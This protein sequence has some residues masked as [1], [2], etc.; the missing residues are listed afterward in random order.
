[1]KKNILTWHILTLI[2]IFG[3]LAVL[4]G[5]VFIASS[6][7]APLY[8]YGILVTFIGLIT[9]GVTFTKY[10]DPYILAQD[11]PSE[12][13]KKYS[14]SCLVAV[15]NEEKIIEQCILSMINQTYK[16]KEIIIINDA[17]TDNTKE[18]LDKY[19]KKGLIN[20]IHLKENVGKKKAL[21]Q[22]MLKAKGEIFAFSDSDSVWA[23]DA[24]EK[25]VDVFGV[26][27][28]IGAVSG[29][30]R[31]LNAEK[32]IW[33]KVQDSWYE[34]QYSIR[35]AFESVYGAVTCVSGPLAVFRREAIFNFI[36][37]WEHDKFLG[38]EFRFATD[39]TL[40][41]FVL[42][43]K[44]IGNKL[45]KKYAGSPFLSVDYPLKDWKIVYCKSAKAWTVVPET[46]KKMCLQQI[47]WKKSFIRNIFFTGKFYW[48]KPIL[49]AAGYY[50]HILFVLAGPFIAF[51]HL[52]YLPLQGNVYSAILY[53]AG[54]TFVGL[55][56]G[57]AY[58]LENKNCNRWI[59]RP[60]MSLLSSL[61]YCWLIFYSIVTIKKNIWV[62]G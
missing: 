57:I 12:K 61:I 52:V 17:S 28:L 54:I 45:K 53:L 62:R 55:M 51:R 26:D 37:A 32:N 31:V 14:V 11:I 36:P 22:G 59:Y 19:A 38:Q 8:L 43:S 56:F 3:I 50:L 21:A 35:K 9:F 30:C 25:I 1:M 27:P 7:N 42:G 18:V 41:G 15:R 34:G 33:T 29:H 39:R 16:N 60:I 44:A 47:R 4:I 2:I 58:K 40:T 6:P 48:R 20:V 49:P 5:K 23:P 24:L 10:K 46:F 13:R